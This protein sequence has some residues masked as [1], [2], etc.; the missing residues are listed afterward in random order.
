MS[1]DAMAAALIEWME[2]ID[3]MIDAADGM[4]ADLTRR[5]WSETAAEQIA[6][7][8]LIAAIEKVWRS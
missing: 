1:N 2:G 3:P 4:R 6:Q 7:S 8:W 5:G